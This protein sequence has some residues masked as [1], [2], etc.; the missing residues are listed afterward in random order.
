MLYLRFVFGRNRGLSCSACVCFVWAGGEFLACACRLSSECCWF[1]L[2]VGYCGAVA[3]G[4]VSSACS[5]RRSE[6]WCI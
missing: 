1:G 4:G 6:G 5:A 3:C 2:S